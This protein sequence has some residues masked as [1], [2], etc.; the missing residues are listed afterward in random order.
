MLVVPEDSQGSF[1][2]QSP[3]ALWLL[4]ARLGREPLC[5][6]QGHSPGQHC[7][8]L[9]GLWSMQL[10]QVLAALWQILLFHSQSQSLSLNVT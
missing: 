3:A 8:T 6:R 1:V 7:V 9:K 10:T 2:C 5:A 4:T